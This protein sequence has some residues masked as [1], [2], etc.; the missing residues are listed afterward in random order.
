MG[1][2]G[3]QP[4]NVMALGRNDVHALKETHFILVEEKHSKF[5]KLIIKKPCF[6]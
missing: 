3:V 2:M 5:S 6:T 1:R 4:T